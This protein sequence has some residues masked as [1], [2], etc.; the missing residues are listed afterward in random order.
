MNSCLDST[1]KLL[2]LS[3]ASLIGTNSTEP[4][5]ND[6]FHEFM[7]RYFLNDQF[8]LLSC[9]FSEKTF[10]YRTELDIYLRDI[11]S[12]FDN[13]IFS[14]RMF[15]EII[16]NFWKNYS[17]IHFKRCAILI[18]NRLAVLFELLLNNF[19]FAFRN[20]ELRQFRNG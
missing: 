16:G 1:F 14:D 19:V 4:T 6:I 5:V 9:N 7:S 17:P 20:R 15:F 3:C 11:C 12:D 13:L 18:E 8:F 2:I 10:T